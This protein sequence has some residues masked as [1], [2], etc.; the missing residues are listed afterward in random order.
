MASE[1]KWALLAGGSGGVGGALCEALAADGWDI[2]L[3]YRG[4]QERAREVADAVRRRGRQ[5]SVHQ[6]D[7]GDEAAT[8]E[9]VAAA[10]G[11]APLHGVVYAAGPPLT[12]DYAS[13]IPPAR[14]RE[15][16][17]GDTAGAYN[18]LQPSI[19]RLR[20]TR[21]AILSVTTPGIRRVVKKH[22]LS[23]PP[24]AAI[25]AIVRAIAAEEGRNGI[26]ANCL[27]IG[28]IEDGIWDSLV[29]QGHYSEQNLA[30]ARR[31]IALGSIGRASD[32]AAMG[33]YLMSPKAAWITGQ[34]FD[35]D[36]GYTV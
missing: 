18:L 29:E 2:A 15:Q 23:A 27:G 26:R 36:G 30:N 19:V 12:I 32:V 22:V 17:L 5:A 13:N 16:L 7:L 20:E 3:T 14:M 33:A 10:G 35:V 28:L 4:N 34:T 6:L 9:L 25:E 8:A 24:K 21:G 31:E 1:E 11:D